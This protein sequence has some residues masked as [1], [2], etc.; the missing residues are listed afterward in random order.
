MPVVLFVLRD[1]CEYGTRAGQGG[2]AMSDR[3]DVESVVKTAYA[4]RMHRDMEALR[5][6][7][8]EDARFQM[9]GS[10]LASAVAVKTVGFSEYFPILKEMITVFE[11]LDHQILNMIVDGPK[12]AV[13]W[14]GK[15]RSTVTGETVET[16]LMDF[17]EIRDGRI[18]SLI[19][20][21]DTALAQ[22][23]MSRSAGQSAA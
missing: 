21:C 22:Q 19:E 15:I 3:S 14:R 20:F 11:W 5:N 23:L 16:E 4:A 12:A 17:F 6:V 9:A 8:S 18:A 10:N 1:S 7:F 2:H 13:H